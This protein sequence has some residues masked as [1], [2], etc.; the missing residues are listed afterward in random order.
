MSKVLVTGGAGFVGVPTVRRLVDGGHEVVVFDNYTA[1]AAKR[2]EPL[3]GPR[4]QLVEGDARD[5]GA[6]HAAMTATSPDAVIHL[7]AVHFIPYCNAHPGETLAVNVQGLQHILDASSAAQVERLVFAST[8]DV[9][10]PQSAA[11]SENDETQPNGVYGASKLMGEWLIRFWRA[12]GATTRPIAARLFNVVGPGETTPHVLAD[13]F[14]YL[15]AGDVLSLGNR[16]PRRDYV[17]VEDVAR[18][19]VALLDVDQSD[20]AV[21]VGSGRSWSV[22]DLVEQI[23]DITGRQLV[24]ETDP[25]KVRASDRPNLQADIARLQ[26]VL[27]DFSPTPLRDALTLML[28]NEGLA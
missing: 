3:A 13:I 15:R 4:V 5:A 23:A 24:V 14:D 20:L 25:G 2:L 1:G 27:P 22:D 19:L 10:T 21:N 11:H 8:A 7:A 28:Q 6:V 17:F 9:Y 12:Q 26:S 18:V 16:T